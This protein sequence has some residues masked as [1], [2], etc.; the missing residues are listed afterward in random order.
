MDRDIREEYYRFIFE[1]SLDAILL[2]SPDGKIYRAN[3]AACIIL[4]R[5]EEEILKLGRDGIVDVDDPRLI[6]AL[7]E[8][9]EKGIIK[10]ELSMLR[11][12]GSTFPVC[13]TSALFTDEQGNT[14]TAIIF[15]DIT[16]EKLA[17]QALRLLQEETAY[18]AT[19]DYL[20]GA[21]NRRGFIGNLELEMLRVKSNN[22]SLSL[23]MLD[24]DR[25]KDINDTY[26]HLNG[27]KIL[28]LLA[29]R[30]AT[31]LRSYDLLGRYGGDEFIIALP[32]SNYDQ[33]KEVAERLRKEIEEIDFELNDISIKITA[34]LGI[35]VYDPG[36]KEDIN[37]LI[38]RV[39]DNMYKA[40]KTRN[41]VYDFSGSD[42]NR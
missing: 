17:E 21:L 41:C 42:N 7:R 19:Y 40:K 12:D 31:K 18:I 32:H 20:T 33:A 27:D 37:T 6:P 26:G 30:L 38:S 8:R 39:D 5:S 24:I 28:S 35:A 23:I 4:Q 29:D 25:F 34:S 14:W 11:Q 15:R 2:T 36:S 22:A 3:P 9:A 13:L 1:K 16:Q 10:T